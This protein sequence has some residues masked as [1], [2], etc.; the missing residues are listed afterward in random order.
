MSNNAKLVRVYLSTTVQFFSRSRIA[1][2]CVVLGLIASGGAAA[3]ITQIL[4]SSGDGV[5]ALDSPWGVALDNDGNVFVAGFNSDNV[6]KIARDG[7]ITQVLDSSGDGTNTLDSPYG[8]A[9][10]DSSFSRGRVYVSGFIS[11]NVFEIKPNGDVRQMIGEQTGG[12]NLLQFPTGVAVLSGGDIWVTGSGS[13]NVYRVFLAGGAIELLN[14]N[15]AGGM[16]E[17]FSVV[18]DQNDL[19]FVSVRGSNKVV[20]YVGGITVAETLIDAS[21]DGETPL[22]SPFDIARHG[23]NIF[24]ASFGSDAVF[25]VTQDGIVTRIIG[26]EGDGVNP[27]STPRGMVVDTFGNVYVAGIGSDNVFRITAAGEI[28]QIID[29]SGDGVNPL[30]APRALAVDDGG[31]VIVSGGGSNNVFRITPEVVLPIVEEIPPAPGCDFGTDDEALQ[32]SYEQYTAFAAPENGLDGRGCVAIY[33]RANGQWVLDAVLQFPANRAGRGFG[34]SLD[35]VDDYLFVGA[36]D[37]TPED[38]TGPTPAIQAALYRRIDNSLRWQLRG[39]YVSDDT[40]GQDGFGSSVSL[41]THFDAS[42]QQVFNAYVS[43]PRADGTGAILAYFSVGDLSGGTIFSPSDADWRG[44]DETCSGLFTLT[45]VGEG[46][47]GLVSPPTGLVRYNRGHVVYTQRRTRA[48]PGRAKGVGELFITTEH[49]ALGDVPG[50]IEYRNLLNATA[51]ATDPGPTV[52]GSFFIGG[53]R[54]VHRHRVNGAGS[55]VSNVVE[56]RV[57]VVDWIPEGT[58]PI[59][60]CDSLGLRPMEATQGGVAT[61]IVELPN[62]RPEFQFGASFDLSPRG[63]AVGAPGIN[64]GDGAVF[65][66]DEDYQLKAEIV[67]N[68]DVGS[69]GSAVS[70]GNDVLTI[71]S[72]D[73]N[74][75]DGN[76][77]SLF[78]RDDLVFQDGF[79]AP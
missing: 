5:N 56:G 27:L 77:V 30:D 66:Y 79:E 60:Y 13:N 28:T 26:P 47:R 75:A 73:N 8:L 74:T 25:K 4:D 6:F 41:G 10:S 71:R 7:T 15:S 36:P 68:S 11:N 55:T 14:V 44:F 49:A 38:L 43:A 54:V 48:T 53:G 45:R 65:L 35:L 17:P 21:G 51:V 32:V 52:K 31:A 46:L 70:L 58:P 61:T 1:W 37:A 3:S 19:P 67:P 62:S 2:L 23:S 42:D 29:A 76:A 9:V 50:E 24:V 34:R 57:I 63:L 64:A 78:F 40:T 69:F 59:S 18:I 12:G 33:E 39:E 16:I 20:K 22:S 72:F